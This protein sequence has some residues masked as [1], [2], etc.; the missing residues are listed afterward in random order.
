ML[1]HYDLEYL[2][3]PGSQNAIADGLSR[4]PSSY[5]E[6]GEIKL[7]GGKKQG[8]KVERGGITE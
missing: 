7:N 5:F 6:K 8:G 1:S 2:H 4:I 3:V